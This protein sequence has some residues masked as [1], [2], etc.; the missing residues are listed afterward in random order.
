[1]DIEFIYDIPLYAILL[2]LTL[3]FLASALLGYQI[4]VYLNKKYN[5]KDEVS[6]FVPSTI[7]GLLALILG[8]TLSMAV[9]RFDIRKHLVL[10]EAN[11]IGT[12]Y[13]RTDVL[14]EPYRSRI[15]ENLKKYV[16]ERIQ[17]YE[18]GYDF[19]K[20]DG[21][22]KRTDELHQLI[23]A[24]I[25]QFTHTDH[26]TIVNLF[27]SAMNDV[28]DLAGERVFA[29]DNHVPEIVY[30]II[31]IVTL[32][33]LISIGYVEGANQKSR[34][35][36]IALLSL[37]FAVVIIMIQDLD[38]PRRGLIKVSQPSLHLLKKSLK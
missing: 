3:G 6:N 26:R 25:A 33:G 29:T 24:D 21:V 5:H 13:L 28:I 20:I 7:L 17:F 18:V 9:S 38:R 30:L 15:K 8:F 27:V 1:M 11:A 31:I 16:D 37:L 23:W 19:N 35:F 12:A 34:R 22:Q 14:Q 4:G 10:K 36:G 2:I 32:M